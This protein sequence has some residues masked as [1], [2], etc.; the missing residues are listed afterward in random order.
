MLIHRIVRSFFVCQ[1]TRV[2][3][4]QEDVPE[5]GQGCFGRKATS[6][7]SSRTNHDRQPN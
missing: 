7:S 6:Q 4:L 5:I 3:A 2:T 1:P